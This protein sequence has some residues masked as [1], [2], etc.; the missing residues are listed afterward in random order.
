[1]KALISLP[2]TTQQKGPTKYSPETLDNSCNHEDCKW[3]WKPEH[4]QTGSYGDEQ[5]QWIKL[6]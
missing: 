6:L 3:W 4:D 5:K 1:M 2:V